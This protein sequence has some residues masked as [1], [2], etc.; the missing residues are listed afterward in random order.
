MLSIRLY[1]FKSS[2]AFLIDKNVSLGYRDVICYLNCLE[3]N[4]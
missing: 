3:P 1:F 2:F 4:F